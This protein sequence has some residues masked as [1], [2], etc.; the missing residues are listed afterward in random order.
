MLL[1]VSRA[2]IFNNGWGAAICWEFIRHHRFS[3]GDAL[4]FIFGGPSNLVLN[5]LKA[6]LAA[7]KACKLL[8]GDLLRNCGGSPLSSSYW[9]R[10]YRGPF[11][12]TPSEITFDYP[13]KLI[14]ISIR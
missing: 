8:W 11:C 2:I 14:F 10:R 3:E 4:L 7:L 13:N 9:R 1:R 6:F 12:D 5:I